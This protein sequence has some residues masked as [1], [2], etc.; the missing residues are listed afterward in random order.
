VNDCRATWAE[1]TRG[2]KLHPH[3]ICHKNTSTFPASFKST[4]GTLTPQAQ[5]FT[6]TAGCS[7]SGCC[8]VFTGTAKQ[9]SDCLKLWATTTTGYA[10]T[11]PGWPGG[12]ENGVKWPIG[13]SRAGGN[14]M[15]AIDLYKTK[16]Y[17]KLM[18]QTREC[19]DDNP[20]LSGTKSHM[21]GIAYNYWEQYLT[22]EE[23]LF[24]M[25]GIAIA[26]G[27]ALAWVF[28]F[29]EL[30]V[31]QFGSVMQ[32][33]V[34][35]FVG[36]L[37]IALVMA[38]SMASVLGLTC[39]ADV[40]LSAFTALSCLLASGFA[41]EYAVHVVHH[42]LESQE[43]S[44]TERVV[45]SMEFLF[46]PTLMSVLSSGLSVLALGFTGFSF[47]TRFFFIPLIFSTLVTYFYGIITLPFLLSVMSFLPR[48][49]KV[50]AKAVPSTPVSVIPVQSKDPDEVTPVSIV[51]VE[52]KDANENATVT[53]IPAPM[54]NE[55]Q[56]K[57]D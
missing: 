56:P 53:V 15:Y 50:G 32:R 55:S 47:I 5:K 49:A 22:L 26:A 27:F 19:I 16:D 57:T 14:T 21:F 45:K 17:T 13:F 18:K 11:S 44:T 46:S 24:Q 40:Q 10:K 20:D 6:S 12:Y 35:T 28:L 51:P 3:G 2:L 48:L 37:C 7:T 42:F 36:A 52:P 23:L 4:G 43:E 25:A 41:I 31:N 39:W 33:L 9:W 8:P 38:A 1:N 34:A 54:K 29:V 30:T